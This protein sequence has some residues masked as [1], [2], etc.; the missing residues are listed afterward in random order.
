[1]DLRLELI[2][3]PSTDVDASK[4]F[5]VDRVGFHLDHDVEPGNGMRIVQ[6]TPPGSSCSVV[7]GVGIGSPDAGP[8]SGLHLVVDDIEAARAELTS[9]GVDVSGVD[10]MGGV[11]Y[12]YFSD[13]D[14]NSWALQEI[15]G[16]RGRRFEH[17]DLSGA[18]FEHAD[19]TGASFRSVDLTGAE[20]RSVDIKHV[21]MKGVEIGHVVITGELLDVTINGVDVAPL[22]EAELDRRDPDRP[23]MRPTTPDGFREAWDV[24]ER[25]WAAT[26]DRARQL[27][28]E[29]LHESVGG[30]WSFVQTLRHLAFASESWVG[31]AVLGDPY[32]WRPWSLAW[33]T[34]RDLGIPQDRDG[35]AP[36]DEALAIR[37]DAMGLVRRVMDGLDEA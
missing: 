32:P 15:P 10:D 11:K 25:R 12:A 17:A 35:R 28:A 14:G 13:P 6:L 16:R 37:Q 30:E 3:L 9:R 18:R 27:P 5:Y 21:Q 26:V 34:F 2:P 23:K 22:V 24:N 7:V 19:L 4:A 33:D 36:L 8:V 31:R 20:F 1:M 29:L